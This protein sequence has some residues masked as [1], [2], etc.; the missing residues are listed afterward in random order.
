MLLG[1]LLLWLVLLFFLLLLRGVTWSHPSLRGVA[2]PISFQVVLP[3]F[4]CLLLNSAAWPFLLWEMLLFAWCFLLC[5]PWDGAVFSS[6]LLVG[7]AC[8]LPNPRRILTTL[9]QRQ[10]GRSTRP[11]EKE[12]Q[13]QTKTKKETPTPSR[14]VDPNPPLLRCGSPLGW[15]CVF[16]SPFV[17]LPSFPSFGWSCAVGPVLRPWPCPGRARPPRPAGWARWTVWL[18]WVQPFEATTSH[19]YCQEATIQRERRRSSPP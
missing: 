7:V 5:P 11:Q 14:K 6:S 12:K 18:G 19:C 10:A 8:R 15:S 16:P 17:V 4:S 13:W 2:F 1:V 3:S 9:P